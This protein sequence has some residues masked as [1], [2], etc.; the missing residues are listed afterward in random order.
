MKTLLTV[1]VLFLSAC[2]WSADDKNPKALTPEGRKRE[3]ESIQKELEALQPQGKPSREEVMTYIEA[4]MDKL[5]KF[6]TDNPK[7]AEGFEA[8]STLAALLSQVR[9][10]KALQYAEVAT[11]VAPAAGVDVKRVGICWAM[12][13]DA[14]LQKGDVKGSH[15]ALEK[16]KDLDKAMY[17]QLS[18]Q[19]KQMEEQLASQRDAKDRLQVGKEPFPISEKDL[20]GKE[21]SLAGMKGKVVIIDFWATWCG[22]CMAELPNLLSLYKAQHANGLE[23]LGV[24]LDKDENALKSTVK[25]K[26]M[27]WPIVADLQGWQ[28]AIAQKW[29]VRSIPATYVLDRKGVIRHI[30]LRGQEL[31]E[32]VQALLKEK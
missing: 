9:H 5:G 11:T 30:G 12:V 15:D 14:R 17:E 26:G 16:I 27:D 19:F 21:V 3:Y 1:C 7:T 25:A 8:A 13:A 32:A 10:P 2:A 18:A 31:D 23:V 22:P 20:N 28:N 6:A 29:G 4:A 24:S